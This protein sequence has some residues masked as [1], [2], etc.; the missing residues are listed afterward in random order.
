MPSEVL[1]G[2]FEARRST[3]R[4]NLVYCGDDADAKE[5]TATLIRDVGFDPVD[6]G[7]RQAGRKPLVVF[8]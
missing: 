6:A 2:I 3:P 5:V 8:P 1:F 4:P 7:P